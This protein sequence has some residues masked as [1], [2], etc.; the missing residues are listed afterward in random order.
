M[1][2]LGMSL[3]TLQEIHKI[4]DKISGTRHDNLFNVFPSK[5]GISRDL[6]SAATI[7]GS[8]NLY[9]DKLRI[10]FGPYAQV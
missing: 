7:L 2:I 3:H 10:K 8:P 1:S 5:N 6:I 4:N 9:Y